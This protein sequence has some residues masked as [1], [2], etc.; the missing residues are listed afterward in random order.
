MSFF[1]VNFNCNGCLACVHNCPSSALT[2]EDKGNRR[3]LLHNISL[4]ARCGNCWRVCPQ[5]AIQ[6]E[7]ILNGQ[8]QEV[9]SMDLVACEVC[10]EPLYTVN[11][12]ETLDQQAKNGGEALC[13]LHRK[14]LSLEAWAHFAGDTTPQRRAKT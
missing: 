5:D 14:T 10:G 8:W 7:G 4:C 12:Q 11:Y 9:T 6:F 1:K 3:T 13:P 2:F